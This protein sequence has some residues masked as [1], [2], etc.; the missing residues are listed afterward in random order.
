MKMIQLFLMDDKKF[1]EIYRIES[2]RLVNWDYSRTAWYFVTICTRDKKW[3]FGRVEQDKMKLSKIGEIAKTCWE[4]IPKHFD[5]VKLRSFVIMPNHVHGIIDIDN[6]NYKPTH[7][8][9]PPVANNSHVETRN[10]A[11]DRQ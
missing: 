7:T 2:S 11:S 4:E 8:I 1:H 9:R 6:A 5:N 3:S 10:C